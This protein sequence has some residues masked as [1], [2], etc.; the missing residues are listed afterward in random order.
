MTLNCFAKISS[1]VFSFN[2][3]FQEADASEYS[4]R[5]WSAVKIFHAQITLLVQ[6]G[7]ATNTPAQ[8]FHY[9]VP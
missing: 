7:P 3:S 5:F 8:S 6:H 2:A 1:N 4:Q 9:N